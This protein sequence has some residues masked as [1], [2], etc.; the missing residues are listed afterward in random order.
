TYIL[1]QND[2]GLYMIDQ[3][4]A[5][6]RIK[7]E[8][9]RDKLADADTRVQDLLVPLTFEMTAAE[10]ALVNEH[11]R[12]LEQVG[13]FLE[14]FGTKTYIVR[15]C[16]VWFP[17]GQEEEI[18]ADMLEQLKNERKIRMGKLREEAAI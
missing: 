6:E 5:Q 2:Q 7:Y 15:S 12:V 10:E 11:H 16:P 9:F 8:Y 17:E 14:P 18:I 13:L 4:A 1:A 3:H